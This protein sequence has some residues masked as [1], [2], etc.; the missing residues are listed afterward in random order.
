MNSGIFKGN[1]ENEEVWKCFILNK[2]SKIFLTDSECEINKY[3]E[4]IK[5]I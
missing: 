4:T 5:V 1:V 2:Y 3:F